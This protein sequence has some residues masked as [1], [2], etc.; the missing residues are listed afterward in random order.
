[1]YK[2]TIT[3]SGPADK[4]IVNGQLFRVQF[5]NMDKSR[6]W[7]HTFNGFLTM[8]P[9]TGLTDGKAVVEMFFSSKADADAMATMRTDDIPEEC[10]TDHLALK[11][12]IADNGLT[13]T[14][15]VTEVQ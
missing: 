9:C 15:V 5:L 7:T 10:F 8:V 13:A 2:L 6:E 14:N 11:A 12:Y 4:L 1:M 3:W